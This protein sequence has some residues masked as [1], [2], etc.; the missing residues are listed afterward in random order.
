MKAGPRT[1]VAVH[2]AQAFAARPRLFA[3][4][5][6]AFAVEFCTWSPDGPRA[7][8]LLVL[9]D[10]GQPLVAPAEAREDLPT[11]ICCADEPSGAAAEEVALSTAEAVDQ[12]VR[13]IVLRDRLVGD[14]LVASAGEEVL[15]LGAS[16]PA[17]VS[18]QGRAVTHRVRSVLPEL[19]ADEVLHALLSH[20]VIAAIALTQFLR[21][22]SR[23]AG[24]RPPPLRAAF[25]FDDPNLHW[26][27]YGFIDYRR[28]VRHA[29]EHGYHVAMALIPMDAR[30]PHPGTVALFKH[31]PD[32]LS[33]AFHG[34]DHVKHELLAVDDAPSALAMAAQA[35]RRVTRLERRTGLR[36]DR[37]MMPPHG[38]CSA[39]VAR[40]LAVVGF[41][42]LCAIHPLPW[43]PS[44]P[45]GPLLAGWLPAGFVGGCA[46]VPR[47]PLT[48][49]VADLALR[50]FLDHP[51]VVYGHHEDVAGGL[52]PLAQ[53]AER[54]NRL[55]DV[56][57]TSVGD[58]VTSNHTLREDGSAIVVRPHARRVA[59]DVPAA[60]QAVTVERPQDAADDNA[61]IGWSLGPAAAQPFGAELPIAGRTPLEIRLHG[62]DDVDPWSVA[63]PPWRAWPRL[64]RVGTE[65]RD[66]ALP[67][68][69]ARSAS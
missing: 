35:V 53:A 25:V 10:G 20:R 50:A 57:W 61:L 67:L 13:G 40:S 14:A 26:R 2:P 8:A 4:L 16:G 46:V 58:I 55:G 33:L 56:R 9:A 44:A 63:A 3:A 69:P 24:W 17:W 48:S 5:E 38:L 45:S 21:D 51:I 42:A 68:R 52:E 27:T 64:R 18:S 37:V 7:S 59:V 1:T 31:R 23:P 30:L 6:A 41:D 47:V 39:A 54:V 65:M 19:T 15:A 66:R 22:V 34:N 49:S 62:P 28:L 11:F 12:R 60:S 29:D 43:T 32:R 36:V